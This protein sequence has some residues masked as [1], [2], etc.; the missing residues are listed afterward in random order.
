MA[1]GHYWDPGDQEDEKDTTTE[2][3]F[4]V[5]ENQNRKLRGALAFTSEGTARAGVGCT[6]R[7]TPSCS[8]T[9]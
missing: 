6:T 2:L 7:R 1:T 3:N 4:F 8:P 5:V 9:R